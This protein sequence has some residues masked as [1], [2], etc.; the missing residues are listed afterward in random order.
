GGSSMLSARGVFFRYPHGDF[1]LR[2]LGLA[3]RRGEALALMGPNGSGKT[4]VLKILAG[5]LRPERGTVTLEGRPLN[6]LRERELYSRVSIV[7]QDPDDQLFLPTPVEDVSFGL[8]N[9]GIERS[10]ARELAIHALRSVGMEKKA[11]APVFH[12]SHGEKKR[13][14]LAGAI[15]MGPDF[16]LMDEP[17]AGLDPLG[18][19]RFME[20]IASLKEEQGMGMVLATHDMD[21]VPV[22]CDRVALLVQGQC[23]LQGDPAYVFSRVKTVR[24]AG[25]RLPR[26]AHL[27]EI[28][29]KKDGV[30]DQGLPLTIGEAR[31]VLRR[32]IRH[33]G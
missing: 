15:A 10:E 19:H 22:F 33:D 25:L 7:F 18:A 16:L 31:R 28:L 6:E 30:P 12:L 1:A 27:M 26:I 32:L 2:D 29:A 21:M 13:V 4:T 9:R 8:I 5:L 24:E 3:V 23:P 20:L 11:Q 17:T 14:A